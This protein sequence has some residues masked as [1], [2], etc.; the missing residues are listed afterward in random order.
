[1]RGL[2]AITVL[3]LALCGVSGADFSVKTAN[4]PPPAQISESIRAT[5]SSTSIQLSEGDKPVLRIWF[6]KDVPLKSKPSSPANS[7][8]SLME[9]ALIGAVSVE[10]SGL[11]D[12][13]DNDIPEGVFTAR[14][15]MQPQDGDH[16]GTAEFNT[17]LVLISADN[18]K[19]L[20]TFTKFT[21]MVKASGKLTSSGH[22][23]VISLRPVSSTEG[24]FP[25]LNE[26]ASE[27]KAIRLKVP[28]KTADGQTGDVIFELVYQGPRPHPIKRDADRPSAT[29]DEIARPEC[30]G[31]SRATVPG[32][33][34]D[35][36]RT[37][38]RN[39][40]PPLCGIVARSF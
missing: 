25:S 6:R 34:G 13:K 4:Q 35:F 26:P 19:A 11:K 8:N 9:T 32:A 23:V 29:D 3:S 16:L 5:L 20:D 17:F 36:L 33:P 40:G 39:D 27:H 7:V 15:A 30:S 21:P 24:S 2:F 18:D 22:P 28:G 14:F 12:Y 37:K 31:H 10:S 1:M 38:I